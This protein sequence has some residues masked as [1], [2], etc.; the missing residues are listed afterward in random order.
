[1][2]SFLSRILPAR[3]YILARNLIEGDY[4]LEIRMIRE[5]LA[6]SGGEAL[7]IGCGNGETGSAGDGVGVVGLDGDLG[8][9]S[10][11][12]GK[13]Y[14]ALVCGDI[15]ALPFGDETFSA[16]VMC[17]LGHHLAADALD[18]TLRESLRIL[19][20]GGKLV[21]LDPCPP[22]SATTFT[23]NLIAAIEIG[24]HHRDAECVREFLGGFRVAAER[25]FRKGRFDFYLL[26]CVKV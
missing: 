20:P 7:D 14:S 21:Y 2:T 12:S 4:S 5:A 1:M 11:A 3:V 24:R 15:M 10:L 23:H 17:K 25:R 13:G 19:K 18:M 6:G 26:E 22:S 16:A 8:L 9:L